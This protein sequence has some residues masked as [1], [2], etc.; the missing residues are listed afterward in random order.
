MNG[1]LTGG[2]VSQL[3]AGTAIQVRVVASNSL[4][5][6]NPSLPITLTP[7]SLPSAPGPVL[8]TQYGGN[9]LV[10]S[11]TAPTDT[12]AND[13]T[14]VT[15]TGYQ[16]EVDEGFGL[17]FVA[18]L[19]LDSVLDGPFG[20]TLTYTHTNLILGHA[21]SYQVKARNLMGYGAYSSIAQSYVPRQ[22]PGKPPSP[23]VLVPASLTSTVIVVNYAPII[24]NTGGSAILS[25]NVYVDD[26][27][28]GA[29]GPAISNGLATQFSTT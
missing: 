4:G 24:E 6:G 29:F 21:Y 3:T 10:L 28:D 13:A 11:W 22:V 9:F 12:G 27:H 17:G 7:A 15:L 14:T 2:T 18:L 26:G 5:F 23:P 20:S 8:V 1:V 16:L 19:D 25:Y